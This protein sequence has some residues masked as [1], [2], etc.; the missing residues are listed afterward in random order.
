MVFSVS[1]PPLLPVLLLLLLRKPGGWGGSRA[2]RDV[3]VRSG[4]AAGVEQREL[5]GCAS[6]APLAVRL[7]PLAPLHPRALAQLRQRAA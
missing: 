7:G 5:R 1:R 2:L 4:V 3:R 6:G